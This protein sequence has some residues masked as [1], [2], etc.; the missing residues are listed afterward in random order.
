MQRGNI[1]RA[2]V[3]VAA[4]AALGASLAANR[5]QAAAPNADAVVISPIPNDLS[6]ELRRCGQLGPQD[7]EDQRC[8]AVW[9]ENR[10]R[11]FGRPAR[12]SRPDTAPALSRAGEPQ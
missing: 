5:R 10:E 4:A 1:L 7:A 11:F 12:P 3:I 2:G 6:A 8:E 9:K